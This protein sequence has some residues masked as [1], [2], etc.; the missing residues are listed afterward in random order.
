MKILYIS[1][2]RGAAALAAR[3]LGRIAPDLAVAWAQTPGSALE[4]LQGNR[5]AAA[6]IVE[7]QAQS[8]GPFV[9]ELRGLGLATPVVVVAGSV[10]LEPAVDA[11]NAG[12]D[13]YVVAAPSLESDL[14]RVVSLALGR[15]RSR[16]ERTAS[17]AREAK[18]CTALQQRLFELEGALRNAEE[19]RA[20]E[21]VAF[22]DQLAKRHKEFTANLAHTAESRDSLA[23]QLSLARAALEDAQRARRVDAAAA[24]DRL[25]QREAELD[26]A[27]AEA[28]AARV[29]VERALAEAEAAHRD[30]QQ[31]AES[32]LAA[33]NER[34]AA[35]EDL[36]SQEADRRT[37]LEQK[38]AATEMLAR[39]EA[40]LAAQLAET[41]AARI[42]LESAL[43]DA[44]SAHQQAVERA[45][46]DRATAAE[47]SAA[48]DAQLAQETDRIKILEQQLAEAERNLAGVSTESARGRRQLLQAVSAYRTRARERTARL[49]AQ[50]AGERA[51]ADREHRAKDEQIGQIE[52]ERDTLRHLLRAA[53]DEVQHLRGTIE[54]DRQAHDR[55]RLASE[56]EL[57]RVSAEYD[58]H[59]QS[60]DRLQS[61][62]QTLEQIAGEHAAERARLESVVSDRDR[63]LSE[64]AEQHRAA[65]AA[66]QDAHAR[67]EETLRQ[68]IE[69]G[70]ADVERLQREIDGVRRELD[71]SRT[72][73]EAL[74]GEA[75]RVPGLRAELERSQQERRGEF[76]RAPYALCRCTQSGVIIDANHSFVTLLGCRRVDELRNMDLA[77]VFD[78]ADDLDWLLE[79]ARTTRKT[80]PV[81]AIWKTRDGRERIVRLRA[82]ATNTGP[83]E[84]V[85]TDITDV[86]ALEER[87]R[88]AHRI[89]AVGR[90]ASEVAVTCD[91]LLGDVIRGA[92]GWLAA[93]G[94]DALRDE[95]ERL[96][97]DVS[98]AAGFLRQ[99][100]V[101]A[102]AQVQALEPASVQ[103]VLRDLAP[104]LQRVAGDQIVVVVSKSS[105]SFDVDVEAERL[106][107]VLVNVASYARQRM[108]AGGQLGIDLA[109]ATVGPRLVARYPNVRPGHTVLITVTGLQKDGGLREETAPSASP[110]KPGVEL[111]ALVD[112]VATCG[113][114]LWMEA[115][116]AGNMVVKIHLPKPAATAG[117]DARSEARADRGG[118][119]ARWFRPGSAT[120]ASR[121]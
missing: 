88:Q 62:F 32:D 21:A 26:A 67:L 55:A 31:R 54:E 74:R 35:L 80:E 94:T 22:A 25:R 121:T 11:L 53:Q 59:R 8:C 81:E 82:M 103:R 29:T 79:Q 19:R 84:I 3:A 27:I 43:A 58:Q 36:L 100:T 104:V 34:Q 78:G 24:V 10:Q 85:V 97:S 33:A 61:A 89:E 39:R 23:A 86:R 64:Q 6:V 112:L 113:G 99:L 66:A 9:D 107:R 45:A 119:L 83:V 48:L 115:Q 95:G 1:P 72:H 105:G 98:R 73:A 93:L 68:T 47:R 70:A 96:L 13:G 12:A 71:A 56:S 65:A 42:V 17:L 16:R 7:V 4:W 50:L 28:V 30:A 5:D 75:E 120:T 92:S 52:Q 63:A 44:R 108:P 18:I 87:L 15:E 109:T 118:R 2:E 102:N 14:P 51:D 91:A 114:L 49:E 57:Q 116:P 41:A 46:A 110:D 77:G 106:E 101:Y 60:F 69:A 90:L 38:L 20:S 37:D 117:S 76:E 40:E 111:A